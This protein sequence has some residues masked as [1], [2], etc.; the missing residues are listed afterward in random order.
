VK[1]LDLDE[2]HRWYTS[3]KFIHKQYGDWSL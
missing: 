1:T 3:V 2:T